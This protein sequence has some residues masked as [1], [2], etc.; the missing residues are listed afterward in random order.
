MN[1][2]E[3]FTNYALN[4]GETLSFS[5]DFTNR[6]C[7]IKLKVRRH[8]KNQN[9][10]PCEIELDFEGLKEID[11]SEDF[12]INVGY[13]DITLTKTKDDYFY[14]S[15][16]PYNNTGEPNERDNFIIIAESLVVVND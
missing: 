5:I 3:I 7:N 8:I 4:D 11:I 13:S 1:F 2:E 16:D 15:I 14:L 6:T 12:R 10:E 9:F